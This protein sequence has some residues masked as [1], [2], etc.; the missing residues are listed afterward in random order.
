MRATG[1]RI[2]FYRVDARH[3]HRPRRPART[4]RRPPT[5]ASSTSPTTSASRSR[6]PT[7]V[8]I[9][10]RARPA[11]L[12]GLRARPLL[13]HPD[14]QAA[15]QLRRRHLL[16][17]LQDAA[18][19]ARRP[20]AR[21]ATCPSPTVDAAA[22]VLDAAP[23]RRPGAGAPRAALVGA[24]PRRA[25]AARA[26][27]HATVDKAVATVKTGTMHLEP[28]RARRSAPRRSSS[29][30]CRASTPRWWWCA[31]AATSRAS[32]PPSTASSRSSATRCR[33]ASARSSCRCASS[34]AT[35]AP[36]CS[37]ARPRHRRHRLLGDRD[38]A[39]TTSFPEV[40][41]LRREILELPC[42]QSLDDEAIDLVAHAV[43]QVLAH[44]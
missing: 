16:L 28:A 30:S 2:V 23:R 42:H 19:A 25:P 36:S 4:S 41:A 24:R 9:A 38:A 14:G 29:A 37:A 26:A 34:I 1:A 20:A 13:A 32:P 8:A 35:S 17:P 39:A 22:A 7:R 5:C 15:R 12:R 27:S 21:A 33:P 3:A 31:A 43:K 44:A 40:A 18:G 10:A 6:S 11:A